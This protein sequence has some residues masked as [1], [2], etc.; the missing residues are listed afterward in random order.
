VAGNGEKGVYS[1][2]NVEAK[3]KKAFKGILYR[4]NVATD[5]QSPKSKKKGEEIGREAA[6]PR[7]GVGRARDGDGDILL[8]RRRDGKG[9]RKLKMCG[10]G[11]VL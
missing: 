10:R 9:G 4:S 7:R 1:E 8:I 2:E 6:V 11:W 3:F 5:E